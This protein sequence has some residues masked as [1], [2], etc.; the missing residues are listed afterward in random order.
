M[1][2]TRPIDQQ[3]RNGDRFEFGA[4]WRLFLQHLDEQRI[5]NAESSLTYM[6]NMTDLRGKRFLDVGSGSGLFSL[7]ARRLG[8]DVL[9]F[10]YDP[11]SVACTE[12]LKHRF[13]P[14]D[15][16]WNIQRG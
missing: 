10:D 9:S 8:A 16:A 13:Y 14:K 6:L 7:A 1:I 2:E 5:A 12:E 15:S 3:I 11:Q 4:N